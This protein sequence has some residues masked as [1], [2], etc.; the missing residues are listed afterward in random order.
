M[1]LSY[2]VWRWKKHLTWWDGNFFIRLW[3]DVTSARC[4]LNA[5]KH[6]T[7][8]PIARIN[9]NRGL[10]GTIHLQCS[11]RQGCPVSPV[12]FNLLIEPLAQAVGQKPDLDSI[13]IKG[14]EHKICLMQTTPLSAERNQSEIPRLMVF[15]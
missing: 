12:L 7:C 3:K 1:E 15:L 2:L 13:T 8:P 5:S 14:I 9:V 6:Y 10:S 11:S 4:S